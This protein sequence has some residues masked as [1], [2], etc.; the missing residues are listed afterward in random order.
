MK[1]ELVYPHGYYMQDYMIVTSGKGD[2]QYQDEPPQIDGK[3]GRLVVDTPP[4]KVRGFVSEHIRVS[5]GRPDPGFEEF[6]HVLDD[7]QH[8]VIFHDRRHPSTIFMTPFDPNESYTTLY[9]WQKPGKVLYAPSKLTQYVFR[10]LP[11]HYEEEMQRY[12]RE[13]VRAFGAALKRMGLSWKDA[14]RHVH[15]DAE[16]ALHTHHEIFHA[17][18]DSFYSEVL[19]FID[20]PSPFAVRVEGLDDVLATVPR[21]VEQVI[22]HNPSHHVIEGKVIPPKQPR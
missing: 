13:N 3:T 16:E 4:A 19:P 5:Y 11:R 7:R 2:D 20:P 15:E 18:K 1:N 8:V 12:E 22:F 9:Q 6:S 21:Q 17:L 14:K 10:E